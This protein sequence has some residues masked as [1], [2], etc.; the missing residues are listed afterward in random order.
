VGSPSHA[1]SGLA[2]PGEYAS[3]SRLVLLSTALLCCA[4][5]WFL[6]AFVYPSLQIHVMTGTRFSRKITRSLAA[7]LID[8]VHHRMWFSLSVLGF[9]SVLVPVVKLTSTMALICTLVLFPVHVVHRNFE[10]VIWL[11][12]SLASYQLVDL[13]IAVLFVAFFN[14]DSA[15]AELLPGF[16]Y[17]FCY[18]LLSLACSELLSGAF[19]QHLRGKSHA[20]TRHR[21]STSVPRECSEELGAPCSGDSTPSRILLLQQGSAPDSGVKGTSNACTILDSTAIWFFAI[22]FTALLAV[23]FHDQQPLLEVR[24]L[25]SG[26]TVDRSAHSIADLFNHVLPH[27][28]EGYVLATVVLMNVIL[29]S[30]YIF[31]L[32]ASTL[33]TFAGQQMHLS[34]RRASTQPCFDAQSFFVI[35]VELLRPWVT[36]DVFAL[37]ALVFLFTVQDRQTLTMTPQGSYTFYAFLGA[38]LSFFFLRWFVW[39]RDEVRQGGTAPAPPRCRLL[40][41]IGAWVAICAL[42]LRGVPGSSPHFDFPTLDSICEQAMPLV[43]STVRHQAPAAFGDCDDIASSPPQPCKGSGLLVNTTNDNGFVQAL[44]VG[45]VDTIHLDRCHLSRDPPVSHNS[46]Q[47]TS[48]YHLS[49]G[50]VFKHL[51]LFLHL[52]QCGPFGCTRMNSADNCCG[53]DIRFRL[54]FS[55]QCARHADSS[56]LRSIALEKC[57]IDPLFIEKK[58]LKQSWVHL[59]VDAADISPQVEDMVKKQL[60][61]FISEARIFWAGREMRIHELLNQLIVYN[62]LDHVGSC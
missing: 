5:A 60:R 55:M 23:C 27:R 3:C 49:I 43:D 13:Y 25:V 47:S 36:P 6:G 21:P 22:G 10:P 30:L 61:E 32:L 57:D 35:A 15:Q 50:G 20:L 58:L 51:R 19:S 33:A 4:V 62:S 41:L 42:I 29:P 46:A 52:K 2:D 38:G 37:A 44:W 56:S 1:T 17:F 34:E 7:T 26:V 54:A 48:E 31:L 59:A 24:A 8:L 9:F 11:L 40:A 39:R 16:H 18:C 14:S 53:D 12:S 45:G 28:I